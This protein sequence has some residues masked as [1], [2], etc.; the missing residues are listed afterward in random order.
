MSRSSVLLSVLLV[1]TGCTSV[2][3]L[4]GGRYIVPR[5]AEVR[6]PFG[7][8][9]GFAMLQSCDG[10]VQTEDGL[11]PLVPT[12]EYRNCQGVTDWQPM[13]SQGQGGQIVQGVMT[14]GGLIGLG[15][16]MPASTTTVTGGNATA[17]SSATSSSAILNGMGGGKH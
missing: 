10:V 7:T 3:D 16:V 6:S 17:T 2:V 12:V 13:F 15:A 14:F 11:Q 8:N 5:A 1:I 4:G 9:M